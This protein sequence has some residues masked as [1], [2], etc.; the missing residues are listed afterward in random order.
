[1]QTERRYFEAL[2]VWRHNAAV[3][4]TVLPRAFSPSE[5][6]RYTERWLDRN[7]GDFD[8]VWCVFDVDEF[9]DV[10][11]AV[12]QATKRG[13]SVAV[14][15]PCFELWLLLHFETVHKAQSRCDPLTRRMRGHLPSYTKSR[16]DTARLRAGVED[17]IR[18]AEALD[19]TGMA[20]DQNPSTGV[21]RLVRRF[22]E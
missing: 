21:W 9:P 14:S 12:R 17:A 4:V 8:E 6:V 10:E 19:P 1:M 16:F 5:L 3:K 2:K 13:F 11:A 7:D 22:G 20:H 15:N 18:R